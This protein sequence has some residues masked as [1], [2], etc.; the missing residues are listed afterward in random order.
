MGRRYGSSHFG[1]RLKRGR[2]LFSQPFVVDV[3]GTPPGRA[4]QGGVLPPSSWPPPAADEWTT[5]SDEIFMHNLTPY[6]VSMGS[7]AATCSLHDE[8]ASWHRHGGPGGDT[9]AGHCR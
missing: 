6:R 2:F 4:P 3:Q 7:R 8:R 5:D 9:P 1:S